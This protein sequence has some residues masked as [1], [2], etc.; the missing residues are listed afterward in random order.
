M[1][2]VPHNNFA[3]VKHFFAKNN[4]LYAQL[5]YSASQSKISAVRKELSL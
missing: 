5:I 1:F 4:D 3:V 2:L